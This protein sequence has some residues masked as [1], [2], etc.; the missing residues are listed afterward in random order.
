MERQVLN[1][2]VRVQGLTTDA[3]AEV[4][5]L[6]RL[7]QQ[8]DALEVPL[9]LEPARPVPGDETNQFLYYAR[10][11]LVGFGSLPPD[12]SMELLGMVHPHCRRQGIGRILL[13]AARAE[14]QRRGVSG[15][16]LVCEEGS[17]PGTAFAQ[18]VGGQYS[19][20]EYRMEL[21]PGAARDCPAP[22]IRLEQSGARHIEALS[23]IR[24]A[25]LGG[26]QES[27]RE[28]LEAWLQS[29]DQRFYIGRLRGK[30]VGSL[31]VFMI[32]DEATVYIHTFGVLPEYQRQG[33]GRQILLGTIDRLHAEG[34][35]HI[36]IEVN[37]QN[38][39]ALS[40]YERCGFREIAAYRYYQM[41]ASS[42]GPEYIAL[43]GLTTTND[44]A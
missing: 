30:P 35:E 38:R 12:D 6:R 7:C 16:L 42:Y 26:T 31:R 43:R 37:T 39:H 32:P 3:R 25:A 17:R 8:H 33:Y 44:T 18:A 9:H 4:E 22:V 34:W 11:R 40:L 1:G 24:A 5:A 27:A 10:G 20:S 28:R 41:Q 21:D 15:F 2:L 29:P 36:R 13:E 14:C 19:F 23:R